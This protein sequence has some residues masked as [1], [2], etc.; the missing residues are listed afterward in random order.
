MTVGRLQSSVF[1]ELGDRAEG[2][3]RFVVECELADYDRKEK[4]VNNDM[5]VLVENEVAVSCCAVL[6]TDCCRV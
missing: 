5:I 3:L 1:E 6:C 4:V 2:G